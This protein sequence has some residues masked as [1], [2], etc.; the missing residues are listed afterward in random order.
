M[1]YASDEVFEQRVHDALWNIHPFVSL[2]ACFFHINKGENNQVQDLRHTG[3]NVEIRFRSEIC[4][5]IRT[6]MISR[7]LGVGSIVSGQLGEWII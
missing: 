3:I 6:P 7:N 4:D 2:H 5:V 1:G